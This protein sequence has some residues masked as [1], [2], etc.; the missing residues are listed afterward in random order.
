MPKKAGITCRNGSTTSVSIT[1]QRIVWGGVATRRPYH[2]QQ[3]IAAWGVPP[4]TRTPPG[5]K[6]Y[7]PGGRRPSSVA[8][9]SSKVGVLKPCTRVRQSR[10][11][12]GPCCF[13]PARSRSRWLRRTPPKP[14]RSPPEP[15]HP[16]AEPHRHPEEVHLSQVVPLT[17]GGENAEA[18]WS[19]D[20]KKLIFQAHEGEGCDQIYVRDARDASAKPQLVSTGKGATT[21]AYFLP[22][23]KEIIYASTHL[24]GDACPPK[25]D[26]SQG[27]VWALYDSYD[28]FSAE[29]RRH[30]P[31]SADR[32][33]PATTPRPRSARRTAR[34]SS[35]RCATATS[36]STGW[37]PTARTSSA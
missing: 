25:P 4:E 31:A 37:T 30:E 3:R 16:P 20:G 24:G 14:R 22:G 1:S 2:T 10:R 8:P 11:S 27:Y 9:T 17:T 6:G 23:D 5:E 32:T 34:S 33:R 18:Y 28:I 29:R 26:Q 7:C 19:F 15:H 35:R 12:S 21:C 36:S 13:A